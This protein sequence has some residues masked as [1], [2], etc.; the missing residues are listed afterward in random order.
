[1]PS[2][3]GLGRW[4]LPRGDFSGSRAARD[5]HGITSDAT[6][7]AR[8]DSL[9]RLFRAIG[10]RQ[11]LAELTSAVAAEASQFIAFDLLGISQCADAMS[12]V[13]WH[14]A[15]PGAGTESGTIDAT[16]GEAMTAWVCKNQQPLVIGSLNGEMRLESKILH[17]EQ[18]GIQSICAVPLTSTQHK[19]GA[20]FI[21][22]VAEDTYG[23]EEVRFL[24]L[25]ATQVCSAIENHLA[26]GQIAELKGRVQKENFDIEEEISEEHDFKEIIGR[27][28]AL[29]NALLQVETVAPTDCTVL[30]CGETGTG[31]ELIARAIHDRSARH[32]ASFVKLNCAAIPTGLLE[33]EL[34]GHEKGAFTGAISQRIGRFELANRGTMFLDEIGEIPLELQPKLLRVLQEREFERLGNSRTLHTDTRLIAATNRDLEKMVEE[35]RFRSDLFYRL[36]VFPIRVPALR[37]R[38]EDIPVLVR[39]FAHQ[40][41]RRM[42]KQID[43]ISSETMKALCQYH[44]P[45]NIRELQNVI[46]RAV[47]MTKGS[48]LQV[49]LSDLKGRAIS[50][51]DGTEPRTLEEAERAHIMATLKKTGW[52]ISG[53]NGAATQLGMRRSTLQFRMKKLG[54]S[55]VRGAKPC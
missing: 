11:S 44:W 23:E 14:V 50:V 53:P 1:M 25:V 43:S 22:S 49:P 47:V 17:L 19:L 30:I 55:V 16:T 41:A 20:I 8:Y 24:S 28:A 15:I 4:F 46:E 27:S 32:A 9:I 21:G 38:S 51:A 3:S 7:T 10:N 31:K 5:E 26:C 48:E 18:N 35:N 40:Y 6:E 52:V 12:A 2:Q 37:E 33:S 54:I 13:E 45:G 36:N 39:H 42:N 34:F 29:R